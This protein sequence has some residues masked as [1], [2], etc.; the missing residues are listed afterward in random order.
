MSKKLGCHA[1]LDTAFTKEDS[2]WVR[3]IAVDWH[4]VEVLFVSILC[5]TYHDHLI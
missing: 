1:I 3:F 5:L 2:Q 4:S